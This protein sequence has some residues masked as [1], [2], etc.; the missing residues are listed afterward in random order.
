MTNEDTKIEGVLYLLGK[1]V[2]TY[3]PDMFKRGFYFPVTETEQQAFMDSLNFPNIERLVENL[4]SYAAEH[5]NKAHR[6]NLNLAL[7]I[8]D[9]DLNNV[10]NTFLSM[11][12]LY[13]ETGK[14]MHPEAFF[15]EYQVYRIFTLTLADLGLGGMPEFVAEIPGS[16]LKYLLKQPGKKMEVRSSGTSPER[17]NSREFAAL[18]QLVKNVPVAEDAGEKSLLV[19]IEVSIG[20][21][22]E[23]RQFKVRDYG[24]GLLDRHGVPLSA[25]DFPKIF[26]EFSTRKKGGLG[27][28][29]VKALVELPALRYK[30]TERGYVSVLTKTERGPAW[31]YNTLE[32]KVK[33]VEEEVKTGTEF[34]LYFPR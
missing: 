25:E 31:S 21:T 3:F 2:L 6:K 14:L 27:L 19:P 20:D 29:L 13:R 10:A 34:T 7:R 24:P 11:Y 4:G 28:Q 1:R 12:D 33:S 15:R 26:D 22:G 18:Y 8:P 30:K 9:H 32:Q 5:K 23:Y 17:I 16:Q